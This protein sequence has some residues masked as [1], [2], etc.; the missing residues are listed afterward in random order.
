MGRRRHEPGPGHA[1]AT[2]AARGDRWRAGLVHRAGAPHRG[3]ARRPVRDRGGRAL[4]RP[5]TLA[6]GGPGP[7]HRAGARLRRV[8]GP[9]GRGAGARGRCRRGGGHDPQCQPSRDL[10][11][12]PGAGLRRDLRQAPDHHAG[13]RG[14]PRP[15]GARQRAR[16][17]PHLQLHRLPHG[18]S[19]ARHGARRGDRA[20]APDPHLLRPGPQR[21][22]GRG[23]RAGQLAVR[24]CGV[25]AVA[26]P[27]RHRHPRPPSGRLRLR[28]GAG[29]GD[30]RGLGQRAGAPGRRRG[31]R[32]D[33]LVGWCQGLDLGH[34]R[35]RRRG[36][37]PGDPPLRRRRAG[38]NGGRSSPTSCATAGWAASSRS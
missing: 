5:G 14:R 33:A 17:L 12:G 23:R 15:A 9:A 32:P 8:A 22:P 24:S 35:R 25:R 29:G 2:A 28:P 21:H 11:R 38:S 37:R 34:Q 1:R 30:G 16:V 18:A 13:R 31:H 19:G 26:D 20:G 7:R 6:R 4:R 10:R 36:P 3:P 27:G